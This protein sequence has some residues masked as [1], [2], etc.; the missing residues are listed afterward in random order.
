MAASLWNFLA[1]L[2]FLSGGLWGVLLLSARAFLLLPATLIILAGLCWGFYRGRFRRWRT[3]VTWAYIGLGLGMLWGIGVSVK[4]LW[5]SGAAIMAA[6]MLLLVLPSSFNQLFWTLAVL[7]ARPPGWSAPTAHSRAEVLASGPFT[8]HEVFKVTEHVEGGVVQKAERELDRLECRYRGEPVETARRLPE[9]ED[10]VLA[11][12]RH[13]R[14]F[15]RLPVSPE[16]SPAR[17]VVREETQPVNPYGSAVWAGPK[18]LADF[19][20]LMHS[21]YHLWVKFLQADAAYQVQYADRGG[22]QERLFVCGAESGY[23]DRGDEHYREVTQA[24]LDRDGLLV[25]TVTL[26]LGSTGQV[27]G[28][29]GDLASAESEVVRRYRAQRPPEQGVSA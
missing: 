2:A 14:A 24:D 9:L 22:Q 16:V 26:T 13:Y 21:P 15:R 6:A 7:L 19:E 23:S 27:Q 12:Y 29:F 8:L 10:W 18:P 3:A 28:L 20:V 11:R 5:L 25:E 4:P 17:D 1:L